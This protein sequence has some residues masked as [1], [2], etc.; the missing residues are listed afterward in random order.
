MLRNKSD[1]KTFFPAFIQ[2]VKTQYDSSI[3]VIHTDNAHEL[4]FPELVQQL[5]MIHQFS[6][7]YILQ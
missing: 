5:G 6:F 2:H 1:V 7:A 4:P 3:Q